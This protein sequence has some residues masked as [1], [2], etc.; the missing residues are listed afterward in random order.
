MGV[1]IGIDLGSTN[2]L[3]AYIDDT[4]RPMII[5]NNE[6]QNMTPSCVTK[7]GDKIIVGEFARKAWGIDE[8]TAAAQFKGDMGTSQTH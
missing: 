6:G 2:S 7:D 8:E 4:G 5:A 3:V 1:F